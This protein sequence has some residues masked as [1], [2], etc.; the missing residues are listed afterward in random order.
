MKVALWEFVVQG[1][2]EF[3]Y[4][5]LRYDQ[6]WPAT[7]AVDSGRLGTRSNELRTVRLR[8]LRSP[9][10]GRWNSFSWRVESEKEIGRLDR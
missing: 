2:G 7:E 9:T 10:T 1:S 3:P 6:C 4:D 8:G 5:M